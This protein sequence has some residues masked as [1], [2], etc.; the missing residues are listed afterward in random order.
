[1]LEYPR[2]E[3]IFPRVVKRFPVMPRRAVPP[4]D[5]QVLVIGRVQQ[6]VASPMLV[7]VLISPD[8]GLILADSDSLYRVPAGSW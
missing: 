4:G 3:A 7:G 5:H 2:A 8:G 1:M 6:L